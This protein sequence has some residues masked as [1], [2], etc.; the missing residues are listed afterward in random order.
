ML[1]S[2]FKGKIIEITGDM[3]S[4]KPT[5]T[6]D[7]KNTKCYKYD[8]NFKASEIIFLAVFIS[9]WITGQGRS[10]PATLSTFKLLFLNPHRFIELV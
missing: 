9:R 5:T 2:P 10:T 3:I 8:N 4:D 1:W 6:C 7:Y